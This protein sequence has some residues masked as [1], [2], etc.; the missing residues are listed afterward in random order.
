M[1]TCPKCG[2]TSHNPH[3]EEQKYCGNCH[4]FLEDDLEWLTKT[5]AHL[6]NAPSGITAEQWA[7]R[8][9]EALEIAE[10]EKYATP[11]SRFT[12]TFIDATEEELARIREHLT[13]FENSIVEIKRKEQP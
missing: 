4:Q 7:V 13:P 3:D 10:A 11:E 5:I 1:I 8:L 12:F 6:R 9:H 2:M